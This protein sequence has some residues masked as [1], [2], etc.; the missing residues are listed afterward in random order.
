MGKS[1]HQLKVGKEV[2]HVILP[3]GFA[4]SDEDT[5]LE[6]GT[7]KLTFRMPF[8]MKVLAVRINV[9]TAP[10]GQALIADLNEEGVSIFST[11]PS[12]DIGEKTNVTATTPA[13]ISDGTL[14]DDA[15]M[16][17]D[18]DQVGSTVAGTGFK[19]WLIGNKI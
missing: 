3:I 7:A 14:S 18:L 13:V 2:E 6:A 8:A 4:G 19:M 5:D 10:D 15:E 12:I 1:K 11:R 16:T 9:K 17:L